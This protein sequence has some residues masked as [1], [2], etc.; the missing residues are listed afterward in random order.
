MNI[1]LV[2]PQDLRKVIYDMVIEIERKEG[3]LSSS[4]WRPQVG[5]QLPGGGSTPRWEFNSQM[6]VQLPGGSPN[7]EFNSHEHED[8]VP[9]LRRKV[10]RLAQRVAALQRERAPAPA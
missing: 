7:W 8:A 5:V 10:R 6:G 4:R 9:A 2:L 1:L 3:V